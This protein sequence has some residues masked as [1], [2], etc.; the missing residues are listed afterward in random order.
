MLWAP[1][2]DVGKME[3]NN[4]NIHNGRNPGTI[5]HFHCQF[6]IHFFPLNGEPFYVPNTFPSLSSL[7]KKI[8]MIDS[9]VCQNE[10]VVSLYLEVSQERKINS[11]IQLII[12]DCFFFLSKS[13][14]NYH[15][16]PCVE[17]N[18]KW[19]VE[20]SSILATKKNS[21]FLYFIQINWYSAKF[22]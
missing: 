18:L 9:I 7:T 22:Q 4:N 20:M 10:S 1:T 13:K 14:M 17:R 6:C 8:T 21:C 3:P 16:S 12:F 2:T 11:K 19:I 15:S 5:F